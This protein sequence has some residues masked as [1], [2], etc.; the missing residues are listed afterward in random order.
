MKKFV[1]FLA[2]AIISMGLT[3]P[4]HAEKYDDG[5]PITHTAGTSTTFDKYLVMKQDAEVPYADFLFEVAP[6]DASGNPV[7]VDPNEEMYPHELVPAT[8]GD[9][10]DVT[11]VVWRGVR[12]DKVVVTPTAG[13][14]ETV[15][16]NVGE[17]TFLPTDAT[18]NGVYRNGPVVKGDIATA[19]E[20]YVKKQ[21]TLSFANIKFAEPGVYR[22]YLQEKNGKTYKDLG[23]VYDVNANQSTWRTV[24]VYVLDDGSGN[25][26]VSDYV[27]Y[28]GKISG[29]PSHTANTTTA[30]ASKGN[31]WAVDWTDATDNTK[32][33]KYVSNDIWQVWVN[34][35]NSG[36]TVTEPPSDATGNVTIDG[37]PYTTW[38]AAKARMK[39][40][41]DKKL[42]PNGAEASNKSSE[43]VNKYGTQDLE[44]GK[45]VEGNQGSRDQWFQFKLTLTHANLN[46]GTK[47]EVNVGSYDVT[48]NESAFFAPTKNSAT[49]YTPA[50]MNEANTSAA[51]GT[52]KD[53]KV[54]DFTVG[55]NVPSS[56]EKNYLKAVKTG[57][58]DGKV[59]WEL[60]LQHGQYV[61]IKGIPNGVR[62]TVEET[63]PATGYT[64]IDGT[65]VPV[66]V[67]DGELI[68]NDHKDPLTGVVGSK[69]PRTY[70]RDDT[71]GDYYKLP[72]GSFAL[73][74]SHANP[75]SVTEKYSIDENIYTGVTN[76][77]SGVIPTGVAMGIAGALVLLVVAGGYFIMRR[78]S[79]YD[80]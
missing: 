29:A 36:E 80:Y 45:K 8:N 11:P 47:F 74:S 12:P 28:E 5:S 24:D 6:V 25:L 38:G 66:G 1:P 52:Y 43:F 57:T 27:W 58:A 46:D 7:P 35:V 53:Y 10:S 70:V 54:A 79:V 64:K 65:D 4:A 31:A 71:N 9:P 48:G 30:P 50:V 49:S 76:K 73:L 20:K 33:Y 68:T 39:Q 75:S 41:N 56:T 72:D 62:Y 17:L 60:Y 59:E 40:F 16:V 26:S 3:V 69:T 37:Q 22:Y 19:T 32:V 44:F 63:D 77:R 15:G 18:T 61:Q 2:A 42:T 23:I 55:K 67:I 21:I 78:R 51:N 34:N 13:A 14:D